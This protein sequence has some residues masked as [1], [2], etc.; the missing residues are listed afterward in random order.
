[1]AVKTSGDEEIGEDG[2]VGGDDPERFEKR[3]GEGAGGDALDDEGGPGGGG[4]DGG[5]EAGCGWGVHGKDPG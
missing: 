4:D 1:M 5:A 3:G 2:E